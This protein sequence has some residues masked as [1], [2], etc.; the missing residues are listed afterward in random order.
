MRCG[1]GGGRLAQ[2]FASDTATGDREATEVSYRWVEH[3]GEMQME[4]EA[5]TKQA[6]FTDALHGLG[7]LLADD[8]RRASDGHAGGRFLTLI[9]R[10]LKKPEEL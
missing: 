6:V 7:E 10:Q 1:S 9:E 3:T 8:G 4:I 5:G 2:C